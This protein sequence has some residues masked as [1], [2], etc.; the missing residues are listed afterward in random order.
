MQKENQR[1]LQLHHE[2][3]HK[4]SEHI[5]PVLEDQWSGFM[6]LMSPYLTPVDKSQ[7]KSVFDVFDK[8]L[9]KGIIQY[10]HYD[11]ILDT[12]TGRNVP[13]VDIIKKYTLQMN[14]L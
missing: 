11:V 5:A 3:V 13:I 14:A 10:G 7:C 4:I 1:L 9:R 12:F 8:L 2:M 6:N